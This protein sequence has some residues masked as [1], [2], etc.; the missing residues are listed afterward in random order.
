MDPLEIQLLPILTLF[1]F[2]LVMLIA[3]WILFRR[4]RP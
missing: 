1:G 3:M 4:R 2:A